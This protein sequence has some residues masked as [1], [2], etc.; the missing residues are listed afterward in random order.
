MPDTPQAICK[1]LLSA[2]LLFSMITADAIN[3]DARLFELATGNAPETLKEFSRQGELSIVFDPRK[4]DDVETSGVVGM[5]LPSEALKEM[6]KG[7]DLVFNEDKETGA[8]AVTRLKRPVGDEENINPNELENIMNTRENTLIKS[9]SQSRNK[10]IDLIK[11]VVATAVIGTVQAEAQDNTNAEEVFELSPFVVQTESNTG[12]YAPQTLSGTR[13]SSS[14]ED[15]AASVQIITKDL[16]DDIGAT[17]AADLLLY[18]TSSEASGLGGN[19]TGGSYPAD[20]SIDVSGT[21]REPQKSIRIRGLGNPDLTRNFFRTDIPFDS[22]NTSQ[23]E[24]NRGANA[25]LFGLGSPAGILNNT[26]NQ[27]ILGEKFGQVG[28]ELSQQGTSAP[29][30]YRATV[31][32]NLPVIEDKLS[33]RVSLLNDDK[34]YRQEPAFQDAERYYGALT[35]KPFK[36]TYI[37]ANYEHGDV[38][39]NQP[40]PTGPVENLS[41]YFDLI[42]QL[43]NHYANSTNNPDGLPTPEATYALWERTNKNPNMPWNQWLVGDSAAT[44]F[45]R[46]WQTPLKAVNWA[47]PMYFYGSPGTSGPVSFVADVKGSWVSDTDPNT[48]GKQHPAFAAFG[49]PGNA[50]IQGGGANFLW[51]QNINAFK[52]GYTPQALTDLSFFDFSKHLLG[53][54]SAFQN[55]DFESYNITLEQTFMD[56]KLG[57]ELAF[58]QQEYSSDGF[59]PYDTNLNAINVDIIKSLWNGEANPNFGR[60]FVHGRSQVN[61]H[62]LWTDRDAVRA[63]AFYDLNFSDFMDSDSWLTK[64]LGR[65]ILT[66]VFSKQDEREERASGGEKPDY[67]PAMANQL[68]QQSSAFQTSLSHLTYVGPAVDLTGNP[69]SLDF[70]SFTIDPSSWDGISIY[71]PGSTVD[72]FYF[73]QE[74][75]A[76]VTEAI[77]RVAAVRDASITDNSTDS[78]A[79]VAQSHWLNGNLV[80]TLG[81][82]EDEQ[83]RTRR[84]GP[85][86]GFAV[87]DY[88]DMTVWPESTSTT[89]ESI[90]SYGGVYHV[91]LTLPGNSKLSLH[92]NLSENFQPETGRQDNLGN[93][94]PNVTGETE[95]YG[96]SV[97]TLNNKFVARVNWYESSI[98]NNTDGQVAIVWNRS[99][100][101]YG[102]NF[103]SNAMKSWVLSDPSHPDYT[104]EGDW[105][106]RDLLPGLI[107]AYSD[108]YGLNV[109][110]ANNTITQDTS[111]P[112]SAI[113][114]E[115]EAVPSTDAATGQLNGFTTSWVEN[116]V[117]TADTVSK[118]V[119]IELV[120]NPT[121]NWRIFANLA[122]QEAQKSNVAPRLNLW[123]EE[124]LPLTSAYG[125]L[126]N[127]NP[128]QP[129]VNDSDTLG[130]KWNQQV[131]FP[132]NSIRATEGASQ[133]E[134]REWRFNLVTNY[135][136]TDGRLK[137]VGLGG[138]MRWQDQAALG[139]E[140]MT[141]PDGSTGPDFS[142]PFLS[143]KETNFDLWASY[144]RKIMNGKVQWRIQL[145]IKNAFTDS[146]DLIVVRY[147][148][149]GTVAEVK[150]ASPRTFIIKNTFSF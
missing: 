122:K 134:I 40:D 44:P 138:A 88:S 85:T 58:D 23:V 27:A 80:T 77:E 66:G 140:N 3:T 89:K 20:R 49:T 125:H 53:G 52:T 82:R 103:L 109:D 130:F 92:Y 12:Y 148:P 120:Y 36:N 117:D 54:N 48:G 129:T 24:I 55:R 119:E 15:I 32:Y 121:K 100:I 68:G 21:Q 26:L 51:A 18:T 43:E 128:A 60:P 72:V 144:G 104:P 63:T 76:F 127:N 11:T 84:D 133:L 70:S 65:H 98:N 143:D 4:V 113:W 30:S 71:D 137:G 25:I 41:G 150:T 146:D 87:V 141:L 64:I 123:M 107:S 126:S 19:F 6:L 16:M 102:L 28:I 124:I 17:D 86:N 8:F 75:N 38:A 106:N 33:V 147:Q 90:F 57:F 56:N 95:E 61:H 9:N 139:Y 110:M 105:S 50:N 94:L 1:W 46:G 145:N 79:F 118:G 136:F 131:T 83:T 37:R 62:Q 42:D 93:L 31:D 10:V 35:F 78:L 115:A 67:S 91:P 96:F 99:M 142:K 108:L 112:N 47:H 135:Q 7:T 74:Q 73:S 97:S 34:K 114:D 149:D 22:Y 13:L 101:Q 39:A 2:V 111:N 14:L 116:L 69:Q 29:T 45:S 81:W 132:L 59:V 5:L